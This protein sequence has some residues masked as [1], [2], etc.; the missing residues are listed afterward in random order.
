[1]LRTP[2]KFLHSPPSLLIDS[3]PLHS[4]TTPRLRRP[5]YHF[6]S[7]TKDRLS[8]LSSASLLFYPSTEC[9]MLTHDDATAAGKSET[10]SL[11]LGQSSQS[12]AIPKILSCR[13]QKLPGERT[14]RCL[15]TKNTLEG[16]SQSGIE[17]VIGMLIP[18]RGK[19]CPR[20]GTLA[21][22]RRQTGRRAGGRVIP[23][24][25][26][27]SRLPSRRKNTHFDLDM[28]ISPCAHQHAP[29]Y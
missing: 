7:R 29:S 16:E 9:Q 21:L 6:T 4:I 24:S 17:P 19:N 25:N 14:H 10:D 15:A 18:T 11:S 26:L 13:H 27:G 20:I 5:S 28:L 1:M 22:T 12:S 3:T 23:P 8:H 2:N